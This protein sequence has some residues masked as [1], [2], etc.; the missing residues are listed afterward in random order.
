V[1]ENIRDA[2]IEMLQLC[3]IGVWENILPDVV[4]DFHGFDPEEEIRN[5]R[6]P[7]VVVA[8]TLGFEDVGEA[9]GDRLFQCHME[10]R[11]TVKICWSWREN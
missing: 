11:S 10:E 6:H 5:S 9:I 8:R 3:M 1:I 2:W 4:T 7:I